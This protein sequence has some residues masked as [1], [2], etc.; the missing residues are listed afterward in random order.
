MKLNTVIENVTKV[1][2]DIVTGGK[3]KDPKLAALDR[4]VLE[5]ALMI[6]ALDGSVMPAEYA[7]FVDL[8]AKCR[9][10]SAKVCRELLDRALRKAGYLIAL[11]QVGTYSEADRLAAFLKM[12]VEA[13]PFGFEQGTAADVRR[14][15]ALWV[16]MGV[17]DGSFSPIERMAVEAL[18]DN[19]AH[20]L[21]E[22]VMSEERALE[23][24]SPSFRVAYGKK[25]R[26]EKACLIEDDFIDRAEQI[27]R[28]MNTASRREKAE[29]ALAELIY[30][31]D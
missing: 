24:L 25:P 31:A 3:R 8:G 7:A 12:A 18:R 16:S 23:A 22:R 26:R 14:A 5:V 21:V 20:V 29:A 13:L 27:A 15:F 4:G 30:E 17:S 19:Y 9:G 2:A 11:A 28:A 6:A 10:C 1:L